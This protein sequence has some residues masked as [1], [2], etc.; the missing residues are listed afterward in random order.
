MRTAAAAP[1]DPPVVPCHHGSL[2]TRS[3][4]RRGTLKDVDPGHRHLPSTLEME[5]TSA[6]STRAPRSRAAPRLHLPAAPG[7]FLTARGTAAVIRSTSPRELT[8]RTPPQDALRGELFQTIAMVE[9]LLA[10]CM[11][12]RPAPP[13]PLYSRPA[14]LSV[15]AQLG[16]G[17][18][19]RG[20]SCALRDG[21]SLPPPYVTGDVH[22]LPAGAGRH[23][24]SGRRQGSCFCARGPGCQPLQL[25][26]RPSIP[27]RLRLVS[28]GRTL[29]SPVELPTLPAPCSSS[30]TRWRVL[31]VDI[32]QS[33]HR[34]DR[35]GDPAADASREAGRGSRPGPRN[36]ACL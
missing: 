19:R 27:P 9:L 1:S 29:V 17:P 6:A 24:W 23:A 26:R 11:S 4:V 15:L 5:S 21:R 32:A 28:D 12:R 25:L 34:S 13:A 31:G 18:S 10:S 14:I 22:A 35:L 16:V 2:S 30:A 8:D 20:P 3:G 33:D 36:H 7:R